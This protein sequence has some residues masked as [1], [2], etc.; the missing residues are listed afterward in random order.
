MLRRTA[1]LPLRT[2][3][4]GS[5]GLVLVVLVTLTGTAYQ[6]TTTNQRADDDV[7]HS[8]LVIGTAHETLTSLVDM[9]TGYRGFLLTG[10]DEFLEPYH[11]GWRLT[12]ENLTQ[13][14]AL[15]QDNPSPSARWHELR[16]QVQDWRSS[17]T[18]PG[19]ALRRDVDGGRRTQDEVEAMMASGLGR[20]RFDAMRQTIAEAI[21]AE[22][23]LLAARQQ[24]RA[25][26]HERLLF[27][28]LVGTLVAIGMALLLATLLTTNIAGGV[29]RLAASARRLA[30]GDL[31]ERASLTRKDEVGVAAQAFDTMAERLQTI[32]VRNDTIL[33]TAAEGIIGLDKD[34]RLTFANPAAVVAFGQPLDLLLGRGIAHRFEPD[35]ERED[36]EPP[37]SVD[38][39]TQA[40]ATGTIEY[41]ADA[42]L[43]RGDGSTMPV[44]YTCAPIRE[45]REVIGA[46][47]TFRD[48]TERRQAV[49]SLA[50]RAQELARSN[51]ELEQF[52]YVASHDLQEPLRAVVSYLQLLER[53]YRSELDERADRYIGHAV[54]GAHRMQRLINDLLAYSRA[55]R[56]NDER[57]PVDLEV[58]LD[59]ILKSLEVSI[60]EAGAT[61][62]H[63]PLPTIEG[64]L[65]GLGQLLQN[66]VG[67]ALKFRGDEPSQVHIAATHQN[68]AWTFSVR[69]NG[70]GIAPEYQERIFV[71]FQRL[72]GRGEYA[73][74]GIGLAIC[75]KIVEQ[76][77]GTLWVESTPGDGSTFRFTIPDPGGTS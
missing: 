38:P 9:E 50:E 55:G 8:L 49:Q 72:H 70:I 42:V 33:T 24:A 6:T 18:E 77:G 19:I 67:N 14:E 20:R 40:L 30:A 13:L 17:V 45:R 54:D 75:K 73:G 43:R 63:D 61:V 66:L 62:T 27:V 56:R 68:R 57:Q 65:V 4:I 25:A 41:G 59:R 52:A 11:E 51:A 44:E 22:E 64:D 31:D 32:I 39:I 60:E 7:S 35:R 15:T 76:H 5:F 48:V 36:G 28:L 3:L 47:V 10:R 2:K 12:D 74:T 26:S 23:A 21:K 71:L 58:L 29:G 34:A 37:P 53:R 16:T 46:V 1:D 69:D